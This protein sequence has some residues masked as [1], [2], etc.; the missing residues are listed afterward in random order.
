MAK[1]DIKS[2]YI[3]VPIHP[4]S[5]W[6]TGLPWY[7][8]TELSNTSKM[9]NYRSVPGRHQRSSIKISQSIKKIM[10]RRDF[11]IVVV[12]H[13]DFLILGNTYAECLEA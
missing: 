8:K 6:A 12:F 5:Q 4:K 13:D 1:V 10:A 9:L 11:D 2:A 3:Y 7:L